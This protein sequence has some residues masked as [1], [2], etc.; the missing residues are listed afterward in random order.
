MDEA[1]S[2]NSLRSLHD[3]SKA[4]NSTL[5]ISKVVD[6]VLKKTS[7]L[8]KSGRVII[9]CLKR[10][11]RVLNVYASLG[12]ADGEP[13]IR[14]FSNVGSFDH[15]IVHKGTVITLEEIL[16]EKDYRKYLKTMP[17]LAEMVFA[18]LEIEGEAVG[19]LGISD[20][21][22]AFSQIE[23][24][25]FCSLGS[26]AAVAMD[27]ANLHQELKNAFLH[28]AEA[29][30]E[31]VNSRDPYTGGHVRRVVSYSLKLADEL[32]LSVK[33]KE[34]LRLSA[35]LH[36]IGKIGIDDAI[37]RKAGKL[38]AGEEALMRS[39]P[40]IGARILG[41]VDEMKDIIPGVRHHHERFD[42]SGYPDKLKGEAIPLPARIIAITDA[43]DALTTNRPY[44]KA[45]DHN[46][47]LDKIRK[48]G[49]TQF[50][51]RLVKEFCNVIGKDK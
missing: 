37:L 48:G 16:P 33:E 23:L 10:E 8:M 32:G 44:S 22:R 21:K 47:A 40:E 30:A 38:S 17:F 49:G 28:T 46:R 50:D 34:K 39:H 45:I 7:Q 2:I 13:G 11:R 25:I 4:I 51:P 29:L 26:Q 3:L 41:F 20:H 24:E 19:L 35:I 14:Q 12:F 42:S 31:A 5:D 43:F 6:M 27:N 9:L 15:C 1:K 18:P 36:D